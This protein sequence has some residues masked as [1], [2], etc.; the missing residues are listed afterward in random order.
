MQIELLQN[1]KGLY[2]I[3]CD[4]ECVREIPRRNVD[5][6][7]QY[8]KRAEAEYDNY[9]DQMKRIQQGGA[10]KKIKSTTI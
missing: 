3:W 2:E 6:F 10:S 5:T 8:T 1:K 4:R 9:V 7:E